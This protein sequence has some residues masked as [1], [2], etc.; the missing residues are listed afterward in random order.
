MRSRYL[1]RTGTTILV[2]AAARAP[3][4]SGFHSA[5]GSSR[6]LLECLHRTRMLGSRAQSSSA[7][8]VLLEVVGS[9]GLLVFGMAMVG[10][11]VRAGLDAA[12][13]TN[14]GTRALMLTDT[15]LAE[16]D[17]GAIIPD[18]TDDEVKGDF[19]VKAPGYTWRIQIERADV[20]NFYMLTL[21]LAFN[22]EHMDEQIDNPDLEIDIE[23]DGTT[24][25]RT[26]YRLYPKPA[27]IDI[28][29]DY[30]PTPE[31]LE[32]L[33]GSTL[34]DSGGAGQGGG[35][36]GAAAGD[37]ASIASEMGWDLSSLDFLLEPGGFDPRMLSQLPEEEFMQLIELLEVVLKQGGVAL[38]GAPGQAGPV[39][40]RNMGGERPSRRSRSDERAARREERLR[41]RA[42]ERR[43]RSRRDRE[44]REIENGRDD[45]AGDREDVRDRRDSRRDRRD[46]NAGD[47]EE[48]PRSRRRRER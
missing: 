10:L 15:I 37:M 23:D 34:G 5:R 11:Q 44:D 33:L 13:E 14:L 8:A 36:A 43:S 12:R 19:G 45:R 18:T 41:E 28:E 38:G 31:D 40:T 7:G 39:E 6:G 35:G 22:Q 48:E 42:D 3:L 4:D 27:D 46:R 17:A 26:A 30:G 16:L 9:L 20:E 47:E 24:I 29:R 1:E 2:G 21:E 32:K 25:V